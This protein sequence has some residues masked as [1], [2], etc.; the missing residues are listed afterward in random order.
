MNI[1]CVNIKYFVR[2]ESEYLTRV[3]AART[4]THVLP[5]LPYSCPKIANTR[6]LYVS[7]ALHQLACKLCNK[8]RYNSKCKEVA[9]GYLKIDFAS[10]HVYV[11]QELSSG[12]AQLEGRTVPTGSS[13]HSANNGSWTWAFGRTGPRP[14]LPTRHS[15]SSFTF[16]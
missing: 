9:S 10:V 8:I 4:A 16:Q 14:R 15:Q 3:G 6:I 7:T 13:P 11:R 2:Q 1:I 12:E 5:L